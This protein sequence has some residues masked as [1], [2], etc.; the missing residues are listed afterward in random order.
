MIQRQSVLVEKLPGLDIQSQTLTNELKEL[1]LIKDS[2]RVLSRYITR[3]LSQEDFTDSIYKVFADRN[4]DQVYLKLEEAVGDEQ[5]LITELLPGQFDIRANAAKE[6]IQLIFGDFEAEVKYQSVLLFSEKFSENEFEAIKKH[7]IN[8]V[9]MREGSLEVTFSDETKVLS[10]PPIYEGF[11]ELSQD[12]LVDFHEKLKMAMSFEDLKCIQEYFQGEGRNPNETELKVLDTY[13]SDHCRHTTFGTEITDVTFKG[14]THRE[15]FAYEMYLDL[16]HQLGRTD[17]PQTLMDLATIGTKALKA[18]GHVKDVDESEEINACSIIRDIRTHDGVEPY[19]IQFKNETH[20]HPTEI[21]PFGGAAT[22]LGGAIRDPLAGRAYVYQAMRITGAMDPTQHP[23]ETLPGKLPQRTISQQ[24]ARGYSSYGNQIGIAAGVVHEIYHPGYLA[25]RM[26]VGAVIGSSPLK[27]VDRR[28]PKPGDVILLVGGRTGR[29]GVGGATGSSRSHDETSMETSGSEVQKGNAPTERKIQRLIRNDE[30]RKLIRRCNDFGAGGV[31]VAV[32]ELAPGVLIDLDKVPLKYQGLTATETAV[33]ES[34]ER[35]AMV[36]SPQELDRF[37]GYLDEENLEYAAI[38]TVTE[39]ERLV[40]MWQGKLVVDLNRS[41]L[42]SAGAKAFQ[43]IVIEGADDFKAEPKEIEESKQGIMDQL[44]DLNQQSQK[45]LHELFDSTNGCATV[46]LPYGGKYQETESSHMA[47]LIPC[48]DSVSKDASIMTWGFDPYL[49]EED[50]FIG[51]YVAVAESLARMAASGSGIKDARLSFQEYF[52]RL[53]KDPEIWGKPMKSLLGAL[54][55]Q[56]DFKVPS[57]GG[58]DSMSG[59]FDEIHVPPT[60][61][62]FAV[63]TMP[64]EKVL[65]N[66]LR[67]QSSLYRLKTE[68][69]DGLPKAET[70]SQQAEF[71]QEANDKGLLLACDTVSRGPVMTLLNMA[72][73]NHAGVK[74]ELGHDLFAKAPT[75]F[76]LEVRAGQE[77]AFEELAERMNSSYVLIGSVDDSGLLQING[78]TLKVEET[79]EQAH[80]RLSPIFKRSQTAGETVENLRC[81]KAPVVLDEKLQVNKPKALITVFPGSNCENDLARAFKAA[82][83]ET[84][85]NVF[86]N[87]DQEDL[88]KSIT[89]LAKDIRGSQILVIP[90]G[91]SAGDEPDGSGKFIANAL[92]NP[93]IS[94]AIE[95]LLERR[96]GLILGI[97]NGFQALVRLG[98]VPYGKIMEPS[99]DLPLLTANQLGRHMDTIAQ[100]RVASNASPWLSNVEV[101]QVFSVPVSHGEG[102]FMAPA[103]VLESLKANGQII[104]QY[105]DEEGNATMSS[106]ENPNGSLLAVEGIIS[107]DGRILGKMGHNE[108]WQEG[109]FQNYPGSFDMQLFKAGVDYFTKGSK[110]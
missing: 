92:R 66:V 110:K 12:G 47:A 7:L 17:R 85:F 67:G 19:I 3:G 52:Q 97:C 27:A 96:G 18:S 91:F 46:T 8:P 73:G 40:M 20:N 98:L 79:L 4:A 35:M 59:S 13:W 23:D 9:E 21:E 16:R 26:E 24:A 64:G 43:D 77:K 68:F 25:K 81:N 103:S 88:K 1:G 105:C 84:K 83:A 55:A 82:G 53:G 62:S 37:C 44:L 58:K 61:I 75:D 101:G 107:P 31:S 100:V 49:S 33:S 69:E 36:I 71:I 6:C 45:S 89:A 56:I 78:I 57:I 41:F 60:L 65:G 87:R 42:D 29:D 5:I 15:K 48:G 10:Q 86:R 28:V 90:G 54:K 38:A 34:Q 102:R 2:V 93:E 50:Q 99:E 106:P 109:L 104:T 39:D 32:G 80:L 51:A 74:V 108:R 22:C 94:R 63:N 76:I 30:V 72:W 11:N 14:E 70:L 95:D